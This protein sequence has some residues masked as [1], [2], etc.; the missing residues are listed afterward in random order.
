MHG[1]NL[2]AVNTLR[3]RNLGPI[4]PLIWTLPSTRSCECYCGYCC[5]GL[6]R[7]LHK[8][9]C[10]PKMPKFC[11]QRL[12]QVKLDGTRPSKMAAGSDCH[13]HIPLWV[14]PCK[15]I[16]HRCPHFAIY[17]SQLAHPALLMLLVLALE[18]HTS[19][20]VLTLLFHLTCSE[21]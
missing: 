16:T 13:A 1:R 14:F 9:A 2:T 11:W 18:S 19:C 7:A 15:S 3:L 8:T 21:T 4:A 5:S 10:L 20:Q 17:H 6:H 12:G